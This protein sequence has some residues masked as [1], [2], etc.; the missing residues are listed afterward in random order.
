MGRVRTG[1]TAAKG[2]NVKEDSGVQ[3]SEGG[4]ATG[5]KAASRCDEGSE[6]FWPLGGNRQGVE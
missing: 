2:K 1:S 3:L 6:A 5:R 4:S